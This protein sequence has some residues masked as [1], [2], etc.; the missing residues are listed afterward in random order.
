MAG[1][2][3]TG[4]TSGE[5][6]LSAGSEGGGETCYTE[7]DIRRLRQEDNRKLGN[8]HRWGIQMYSV[9]YGW[10]NQLVLVT[11]FFIYSLSLKAP[12]SLLF[13]TVSLM[14]R[15]PKHSFWM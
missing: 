8:K 5:L 7:G 1:P 9:Y 3:I 13:L 4:S 15:I 11:S 6:H 14:A 12:S 2:V 10:M